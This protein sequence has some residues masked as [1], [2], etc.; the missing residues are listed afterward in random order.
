MPSIPAAQH[1]TSSSNLESICIQNVQIWNADGVQNNKDVWVQK[2]KVSKITE[3]GAINPSAGV[4]DIRL[5][6]NGQGL[7]LMPAGVDA[8]AH[9]RVPGQAH[10]E[11]AW[12]G[13]FAAVKGGYSALL[14]M[15]NTNPV[16]DS[17]QSLQKGKEEISAAE[18]FTGV[19]VLWSAAMTMGQDGKELVDLVALHKAGVVAIT[20]DGKG[21]E[22]DDLMLKGLQILE[23]IGIPFL[24]HSEVPGHGG[25]LAP[26]DF[27]RSHNI[28]A[29]DEAAEV[30]M[31]KRDLDLLKKAPKARYH[32]LHVS[33]AKSLPLIAESKKAGFKTTVEVSPHHL[34]FTVDDITDDNKSFKM[35]PPLRTAQDKEKFITALQTGEIDFVATDHAPHEESKKSVEY[36]QAAFGTL[37]LET[38]LPVLLDL[39]QKNLLSAQKLVDV[40]ATAP[41]KFL[42]VS[43]QHGQIAEGRSFKAVLL[44]PKA[45]Y[46]KVTEKDF[47]SLSKNSCFIGS[48]LPSHA[49]KKVFLN[50]KVFSLK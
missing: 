40:F 13:L 8:Q 23:Q 12:T 36:P 29:Y 32:L 45:A 18:D 49:I 17:V 16:I 50:E 42:G 26:S 31:L 21:V 43:D 22:S 41:A 19:E 25:V 24:Q 9:L 2:G 27:Q 1:F 20:D 10:K 14:T 34:F 35:N 5:I 48:D 4:V 6:I 28:P 37:G 3:H 46:Q 30:D 7:V 15:P 44:D 11:T 39:Y 38:C 47:E 33:S